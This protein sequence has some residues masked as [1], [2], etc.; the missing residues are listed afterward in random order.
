MSIRTGGVQLWESS[1]GWNWSICTVVYRI[2][3]IIGIRMRGYEGTYI[4]FTTLQCAAVSEDQ[5]PRPRQEA[6][7]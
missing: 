4:P 7:L 5:G 3:W 2:P 1:N 6:F